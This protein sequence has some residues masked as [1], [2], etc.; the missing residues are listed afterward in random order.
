MNIIME[1]ELAMKKTLSILL[2]FIML[3]SVL[4][5]MPA[6]VSAQSQYKRV[7]V[8]EN[9]DY[10]N[11]V[12]KKVNKERSAVGAPALKMDSSLLQTAMLRGAEL[13]VSFDHVRPNGT[14]C[15]EAND[16]MFGENIA[17]GYSSPTAVMN[18]WMDS[19]G[20]RSN[21][22][23]EN[24]QSIGIGCVQYNGT[25]Y[26]VQCFG[27]DAGDGV[28]KSG[29]STKDVLVS[30]SEQAETK[31]DT[32]V[33]KKKIKTV[34]LSKTSYTYDG[35][36][37][38]PSVT[39]KDSQ[40]KTV[41]SQYYTVSYS[42]GRKNVGKYTVTVKGKGNYSGTIQKTF[43]IKPKATS[44]SKLTSGKKK[45]TVKW[46]K[47]ATQTTGYQIQYST[48]SKFKN[49]KTVTVSGNKT[50][51]KTVGKLTGKKRYYVRVRTYKT[52]KVNGK[53][54]K[55]YSAWSKAKTVTTKK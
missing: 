15:F 43:T 42:A 31:Y 3:F 10:A 2:S 33:S 11:E 9:Y 13:V 50:T 4:S 22:L 48:S 53:N 30:V 34:T 17:M 16:K 25:W 20:H 6:A 12:L 49:T 40:G 36:T 19:S 7:T 23:S 14:I 39:V 21:I 28:T 47:Q 37:K 54:T 52:V 29:K 55:N 26:W 38:K 44:I 41:S 46:K 51:S 45:F 24:Y 32:A 35:K 18:G 27:F 8:T 5:A 1:D